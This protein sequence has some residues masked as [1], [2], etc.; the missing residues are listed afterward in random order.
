MGIMDP[1]ESIGLFFDCQYFI[2]VIDPSAG[3]DCSVAYER[4]ISTYASEC[5]APNKEFAANPELLYRVS[6][7]GEQECNLDTVVGA[8]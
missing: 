4:W 2:D 5:V 3:S 7:T 6:S 1:I 8:D